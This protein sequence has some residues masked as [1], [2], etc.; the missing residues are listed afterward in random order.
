V[1][2]AP[3]SLSAAIELGYEPVAPGPGEGPLLGERLERLVDLLVRHGWEHEKAYVV[4]EHVAA[5][6]ADNRMD[7]RE[8]PGWKRL[9]AALDLPPWQARRVTVLL[10]GEPGWPGLVERLVTEGSGALD[11]PAVRTAVQ[12]TLDESMRPPARVARSVA[13]RL[14]RKER[15]AS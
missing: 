8:A 13:A 7:S 14:A 9:A 1:L 4:V 5:S 3:I 10:L 15:I 6:A 2:A 11:D 12:A